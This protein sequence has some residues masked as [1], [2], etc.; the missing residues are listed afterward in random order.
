MRVMKQKKMQKKARNIRKLSIMHS[1][2]GC[3]YTSKEY[4]KADEGMTLSYSS[5]AYP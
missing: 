2:C 1:D 5:K 3:Q 4:K